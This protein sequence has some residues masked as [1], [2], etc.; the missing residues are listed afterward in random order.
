MASFILFVG[1]LSW[2]IAREDGAYY[3]RLLAVFFAGLLWIGSTS[4]SRHAFILLRRYLGME[5]SLAEFLSTQLVCL[6]FPFLYLRVRREADR[7]RA[8]RSED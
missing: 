6:F 8:S 7:H 2:T 4:F 3:A 5:V 1:L